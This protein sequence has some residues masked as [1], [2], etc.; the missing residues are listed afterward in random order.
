MAENK[1]KEPGK[2]Q[3]KTPKNVPDTTLEACVQVA[4]VLTNRAA[5]IEPDGLTLLYKCGQRHVD[6]VAKAGSSPD[7]VVAWACA[8]A[9]RRSPAL[10]HKAIV[11]QSI[12]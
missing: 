8:E 10:N 4:A 7:E 9:R 12:V 11:A 6:A 1:S 3:S 2:E 5:G